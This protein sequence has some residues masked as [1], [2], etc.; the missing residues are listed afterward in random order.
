MDVVEVKRSPRTRALVGAAVSFV[1]IAGCVWWAS[2]QEAPTFPADAG[3]WA[4]LGVALLVYAGATLARGYRWDRI[5]R[6]THVQHKRTDAYALITVGYMGNTVLPARGG[7]VLRIFLLSERSAALKREVLGSIVPERMLDAAALAV[8]FSG[9]SLAGVAGAPAGRWPA[10]AALAA[11]VALI[12][13]SIIYL[14]LRIA[15]RMQS[16]ADRVRPVAK[17]SRL[18]LSAVGVG[19]GVVTIATWTSEGLVFWLVAQA[20]DVSMSVPEATFVTVLASLSALIP[21]GP[22]YVGTYDAAALFGLHKLGVNAS[23]AVGAV[24]LFRFVIFV[25]ITVVGLLLMVARYGGLRRAL[26]REH[27]ADQVSGPRAA[28]AEVVRPVAPPA[29]DDGR[30]AARRDPAGDSHHATDGARGR[31]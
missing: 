9:L 5:L 4:L 8:L 31:P 7:E 29:S 14:R 6:S 20:L 17:G 21:A 30:F 13:A 19:L 3:H 1:A 28:R 25:P 2:K 26:R 27:A 16:F 12:A 11:L 15:G 24:I 23:D 10:V 18:L 22:G